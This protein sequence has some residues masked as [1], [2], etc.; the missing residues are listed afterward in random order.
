MVTY[1]ASLAALNSPAVFSQIDDLRDS[2][3]PT[4]SSAPDTAM[5]QSHQID[6]YM[7]IDPVDVWGVR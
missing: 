1:W 5:K 7:N 4:A 6:A 2:C 3:E